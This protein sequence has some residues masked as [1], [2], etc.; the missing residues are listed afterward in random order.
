MAE[1]IPK[2]PGT[3]RSRHPAINLPE[4]IALG[5]VLGIAA[6][7]VF[8]ERAAVLQPIGDAYGAMLQIAVFP[9]LLS[10]LMHSLGQVGSLYGAAAVA[11]GLGSVCLSLDPDVRCDLGARLRYPVGAPTFLSDGLRSAWTKLN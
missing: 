11:L 9:Y 4:K 5:A 2:E 3:S 10:S 7:V 1:L 8:G 6:G